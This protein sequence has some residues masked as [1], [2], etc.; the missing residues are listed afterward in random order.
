MPGNGTPRSKYSARRIFSSSLLSTSASKACCSGAATSISS[1]TVGTNSSPGS[2][3]LRLGAGP[4]AACIAGTSV[5]SPLFSSTTRRVP[6][7]SS[8]PM[9]PTANASVRNTGQGMPGISARP[10]AMTPPII[11]AL[12]CASTCWPMSRPT[13]LG[14]SPVVTRVT[15]MPAQM[16]MNSAGICAI[17]PSPMVRIE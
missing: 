11:S 10:S 6:R 8:A 2:P 9:P 3:L 14:P 1:G 12:G 7:A 17:R 15:M 4:A 16:A 5:T 13:L